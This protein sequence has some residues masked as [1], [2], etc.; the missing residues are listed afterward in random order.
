M[1]NFASFMAVS[2]T[3]EESQHV[4]GDV[5]TVKGHGEGLFFSTWMAL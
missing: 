5:Y 3:C 4:Y 1:H 2:I